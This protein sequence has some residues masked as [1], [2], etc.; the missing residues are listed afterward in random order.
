MRG[1]ERGKLPFLT[2]EIL[3]QLSEHVESRTIKS[4]PPFK[5]ARGREGGLPAALV[6]SMLT[7]FPE[8]VKNSD[9]SLEFNHQSK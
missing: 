7:N 2:F 4:P 1:K 9:V 3:S 5:Q 6:T 8:A